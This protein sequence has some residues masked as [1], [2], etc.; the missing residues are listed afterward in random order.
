M[1]WL[2]NPERDRDSEAL[3]PPIPNLVYSTLCRLRDNTRLEPLPAK[4]PHRGKWRKRYAKYWKSK[5][6]RELVE[7]GILSID[8]PYEVLRGNLQFKGPFASK[9]LKPS[10][11]KSPA[12]KLISTYWYRG[13]EDMQKHFYAHRHLFKNNPSMFQRTET[14]RNMIELIQDMGEDIVKEIIDNSVDENERSGIVL[15][16]IYANKLAKKILDKNQK[17]TYSDLLHVLR[18]WGFKRSTSRPNV[19]KKGV[20]WV[21]SDN[22]GLLKNYFEPIPR[23]TP[24]TEKFPHMFV[25]VSK[26][27]TD[28]FK[29]PKVKEFK[30]T[31]ICLN[32]NYAA[33]P[34]KDKGNHGPSCITALGDFKGGELLL[35]KTENNADK[36]NINNNFLLFDGNKLHSVA[37]YDGH[38]R[39]S[40]VYFTVKRFD[41]VIPVEQNKII[42]YTNNYPTQAYFDMLTPHLK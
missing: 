1:G 4:N 15:A 36:H 22:L 12:E 18:R 29:H 3:A 30:F 5:T 33:R 21:H 7:R 9:C 13:D 37:D 11:A 17:V 6:F 31:S 10:E 28:N 38:E 23:V 19:M 26:Y 35:H 2:Y 27:L 42:K 25:L 34:H 32:K 40:I 41:K 14:V 8:L 20:S 39:Y 24:T 16:R